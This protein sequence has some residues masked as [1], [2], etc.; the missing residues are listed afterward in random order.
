M[1]MHIRTHIAPALIVLAIGIFPVEFF[2]LYERYPHMDK[3]LH[4]AGGVA[5]AWFISHFFER[6][7]HGLSKPLLFLSII[8]STVLI[9]VLWEFAEYMSV[10]AR[11]ALPIFHRYFHGGDLADT[12]GDLASDII[13][14]VLM[15]LWFL[16][17]RPISAPR[18]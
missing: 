16:S 4:V 8:G 2:N 13:G 7:S 18:R 3:L 12:L 10:F 1:R 17:R 6:K 9:G 5:V 11:G 15:A 14:G